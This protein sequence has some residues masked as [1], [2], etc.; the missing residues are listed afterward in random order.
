MKFRQSIRIRGRRFKAPP[1]VSCQAMR[2]SALLLVLMLGVVGL[3][4]AAVRDTII[5]DVSTRAF[6]VVWVSDQ[7]VSDATVRVYQDPDGQIDITSS[8]IITIDSATIPSAHDLGIVKVDVQGLEAD[9]TYYVETETDS[10]VYPNTPDPLLEVTTALAATVANS[11][12]T[13]IT[14][15]LLIH[16]VF[17]PDGSTP[18]DG[19]LLLL[20]IPSLSQY[21]LTAFV[22]DGIAAPST[23]IDLSNLISDVTGTNVQVVG[24]TVIEI[25]EYRGLHCT[26]LNEQKLVRLRRAPDHE[27]DPPISE[28]ESVASCFAPGG[29]AADFNCDSRVGAGDFNLFLA[30]FGVSSTEATPDCK[31]NDDFDLNKDRTVGAGDFNLFLSVFGT[32]E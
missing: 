10:Y 29:T 5:T 3:T 26:N 28:A 17:N 13:P 23:V 14:N 12:G 19:I 15:D 9:T 8:L 30:N 4:Q 32:V 1:E 31:F 25:S 27:E 18:A 21:P 7:A 6:S 11:D 16:E 22:A 24:G 20:K 2:V